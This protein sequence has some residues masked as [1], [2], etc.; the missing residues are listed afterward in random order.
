MKPEYFKE[1][2]DLFIALAP[3]VRLDHTTNQLLS[4]MAEATDLAIN[5]IK[6]TGFYDV[7]TSDPA[8]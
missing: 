8:Q 7:N 6:K 3:V 5:V 2:V 4:L 1:R